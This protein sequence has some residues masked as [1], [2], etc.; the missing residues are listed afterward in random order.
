MRRWPCPRACRR[1]PFHELGVVVQRDELEVTPEP[2]E[3]G[4]ARAR[5]RSRSEKG[6]SACP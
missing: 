1:L 5:G 3:G 6:R 4:Y 2:L